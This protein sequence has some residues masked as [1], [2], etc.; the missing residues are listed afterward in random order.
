M[1]LPQRRRARSTLRSA[2]SML[3]K[4]D[5]T[6]ASLESR[7]AAAQKETEGYRQRLGRLIQRAI[8]RQ[9]PMPK[10]GVPKPGVG[11]PAVPSLRDPSANE[12]GR[13]RQLC[14]SAYRRPPGPRRSINQG[15]SVL[16]ISP[17]SRRAIGCN[18]R[19]RTLLADSADQTWIP[20]RDGR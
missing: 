2:L 20:D 11:Y 8:V 6:I 12:Q 15:G 1:G 17:D 14:G 13:A 16:V 5:V 18:S 10:K 9:R 4:R 19:Y 7:L 3:T